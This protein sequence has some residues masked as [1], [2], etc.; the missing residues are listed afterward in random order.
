MSLPSA[1]RDSRRALDDGALARAAVGGDRDLAW[2]LTPSRARA[3]ALDK[4]YLAIVREQSFTR[5]R[6]AVLRPATRVHAEV[7][8]DDTG[9]A[10]TGRTYRDARLLLTW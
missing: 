1:T 4:A 3:L 2:L 10:A 8:D 6:D 5:G 7:R 9:L